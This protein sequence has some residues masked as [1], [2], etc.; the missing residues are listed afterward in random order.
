[1][2]PAAL[3]RAVQTLG[4]TDPELVAL[5]GISPA[6]L[7]EWKRSGVPAQH[8]ATVAALDDVSRRL[9]VW[10]DAGRLRGLVR[11]PRSEYGGR[12]LLQLLATEGAGPVHAE[13]DRLLSLGLLP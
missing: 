3:A 9:A 12:T 1:M 11:Q 6:E 2:S 4:L 10:L 13:I 5:F 8:A 7:A